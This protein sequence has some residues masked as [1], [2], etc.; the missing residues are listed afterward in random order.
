M[1]AP[2]PPPSL[3]IPRPTHAP[4]P[5]HPQRA[6]YM[7]PLNRRDLRTVVHRLRADARPVQQMESLN[8]VA[9]LSSDGDRETLVALVD[10]GVIGE[11]VKLLLAGTADD[12]QAGAAAALANLAMGDVFFLDAIV[13]AGAIPRLVSLL[14]GGGGLGG[15]SGSY[16]AQMSC[17]TLMNLA[18]TAANQASIAAA[19]AIPRLV[20]LLGGADSSPAVQ[21][22]A[23]GV[24]RNLALL[25]ANHAPIVAA[26]AIPRLVQ[27]LARRHDGLASAVHEFATGVLMHLARDTPAA[28]VAAG[29]IPLL[30]QL[31]EEP[32]SPAR[33]EAQTRLSCASLSCATLMDLAA[34]D[35]A[36][37]ASI[38]AAGAIPRLVQLLGGADS[39]PAAVQQEYAV[40]VLRNLAV[41][42]D[43]HAPIMA[44]GAI[45]RLVQLLRPDSS[46]SV[47]E[48]ATKVLS[49]LATAFPAAIP[50]I[51]AADGAIIIPRLVQLL[52]P[53]SSDDVHNNASKALLELSA[54]VANKPVIA[55]AGAVPLLVQLL[56]P[57]SSDGVHAYAAGLMLRLADLVDDIQTSIAA[58]LLVQLLG[59]GSPA[60]QYCVAGALH[61][62][63]KTDGNKKAIVAAGAIPLLMK[64]LQPGYDELPKGAAARTLTRLGVILS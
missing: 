34:T 31:L 42:A 62:L 49:I 44:A 23:A 64:M 61:N 27:L 9:G 52:G 50:D 1:H 57:G 56:G 6:S 13:S 58:P 20:Q 12:L 33:A 16:P 10:A 28:I 32:D 24:L 22:A 54:V 60:A 59:A 17:G 8:L 5:L 63:A 47:H 46:P 29:A 3:H 48:H 35:Q 51:S 36:N 15:G 4:R 26:G 37:Q 39:S 38:V 7:L 19:G 18:N 25:V 11:L 41:S 30:V 2:P 55:A 43:N 21:A 53:G 40:G 45:P 14:G